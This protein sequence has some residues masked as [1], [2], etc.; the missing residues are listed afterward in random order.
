M[1]IAKNLSELIGNTPLLEVTNIETGEA[2]GARVLVKLESFNP[3]NNVKDRVALSMIEDAE[4]SGVLQPG[5]YYRADIG[6]HRYR[7]GMGGIDQGLQR[8]TYNA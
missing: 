6:Q 8:D 3:G 7:S 5:H 1:K 4:E 2:L